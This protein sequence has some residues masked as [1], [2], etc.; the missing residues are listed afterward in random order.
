M[1]KPCKQWFCDTC[2]GVIKSPSEGD[3]QYLTDRDHRHVLRFAIIHS[4]YECDQYHETSN[5]NVD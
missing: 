4:R 5:L 3:L 2:K 1:L